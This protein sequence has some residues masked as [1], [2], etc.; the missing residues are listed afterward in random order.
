MFVLYALSESPYWCHHFAPQLVEIYVNVNIR[1]LTIFQRP[2]ATLCETFIVDYH[3]CPVPVS[4]LSRQ[5]WFPQ[6]PQRQ[7]GDDSNDDQESVWSICQDVLR[8]IPLLLN[9]LGLCRQKQGAQFAW[10]ALPWSWTPKENSLAS[11]YGEG[12]WRLLI[13][14]SLIDA[15]VTPG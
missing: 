6:L 12:H 7:C 5:C 4:S 1:P 9:V 14:S 8:Y 15:D 3:F 10:L 11:W 13:C 2:L